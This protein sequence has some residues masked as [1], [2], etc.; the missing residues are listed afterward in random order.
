MTV[1]FNSDSMI[2]IFPESTFSLFSLVIFLSSS[3]GYQLNTFGNNIF[4]GIDDKEVNVIRGD[5]VIENAQAI[6]F[7]SS[8]SQYIYRCLSLENLKRNSCLWH[9]WVICQ[10]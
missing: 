3:A 2:T 6:A 4:F 1:G 9:L 8:K 5:N 7:F 10:T